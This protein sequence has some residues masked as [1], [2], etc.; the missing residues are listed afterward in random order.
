MSNTLSVSAPRGLC[1]YCFGS[2]TAVRTDGSRMTCPN[3]AIKPAPL[4]ACDVWACWHLDTPAEHCHCL[5]RT[6]T[7]GEAWKIAGDFVR[8]CRAMIATGQLPDDYFDDMLVRI[9]DGSGDPHEVNVE[10]WND[11]EMA[12]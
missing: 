4:P 1:L 10:D 11:S 3:C 6:H 12:A 2:Q 9:D 5:T 7:L 8:E